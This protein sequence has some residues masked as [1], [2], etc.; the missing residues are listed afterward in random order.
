MHFGGAVD[1]Y[2]FVKREVHRYVA[3]RAFSE[4]I[5]THFYLYASIGV[6]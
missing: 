1:T 3:V 6:A 4:A 2:P 5:V